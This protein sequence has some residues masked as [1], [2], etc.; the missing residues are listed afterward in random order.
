MVVGIGGSIIL[1]Q[2]AS[3]VIAAEW[4]LLCV[5]IGEGG[6]PAHEQR[7]DHLHHDQA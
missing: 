6:R 7:A 2:Y 4:M 1:L 5:E 3:D